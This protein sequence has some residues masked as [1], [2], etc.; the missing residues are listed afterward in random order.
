V[1]MV[2]VVCVAGTKGRG[3]RRG[4]GVRAVRRVRE[5][6]RVRVRRARSIV[7]GSVWGVVVV[8]VV[9]VVVELLEALRLGRWRHRARIGGPC[10][11]SLASVLLSTICFSPLPTA[12]TTYTGT[13]LC[14]PSSMVSFIAGLLSTIHYAL[15]PGPPLCNCAQKCYRQKNQT[16]LCT[17]TRFLACLCP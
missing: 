7:G 12:T 6:Q 4:I 9:V 10:A 5:R 1:C 14:S 13:T 3:V 17:R 2:C 15:A 16:S 8:L 11:R